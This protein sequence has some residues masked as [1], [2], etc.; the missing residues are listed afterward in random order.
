MSWYR[1]Y[2]S[3]A[4]TKCQN[5]LLSAVTDLMTKRESLLKFHAIPLSSCVEIN[6][7]V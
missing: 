6:P 5:L 3:F 4:L 7:S 2:R 1:S